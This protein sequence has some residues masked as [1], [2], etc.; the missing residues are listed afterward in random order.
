M[1]LTGII[2]KGIG[3]FYYVEVGSRI[4]ATRARGLFRNE[5]IKPLVGDRVEIDVIS[6]EE[7]QAHIQKIL[8]RFSQLKRPEVANVEQVVVTMSMASPSPNFILMD[9]L[10]VLGQYHG[11]TPVVLLNKIELV[12]AEA[13]EKVRRDYEA[14]GFDVI[15][16]SVKENTGIEALKKVLKDKV[17][18]FAGPSGV[19]KSSITNALK[20]GLELKV[21]EV[22]GRIGRGRHTTRHSELIELPSGGYVLDTPGFSSLEILDIPKEALKDYYP[23]FRAASENCRYGDCSHISETDCGV[24]T[25]V[26]EHRISRSR[27]GSYAYLY[28]ELKKQ[29]ERY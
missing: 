7:A 19:G 27:Y 9:K 20:P 21:G 12:T 29:K 14:T 25:A 28:E 5:K 3:G 11:V 2:L 4:Y 17:N 10:L 23:E 26:A 24:K 15:F 8:P 22:S 18:V 13:V 6:E 16:V 1:R